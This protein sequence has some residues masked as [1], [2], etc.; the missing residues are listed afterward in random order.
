MAGLCVKSADESRQ[1]WHELGTT[2]W[3]RE[4]GEIP[5]AICMLNVQPDDIIRDVILVKSG[6]HCFNI[7]L[8]L[9]V[10]SALVITKREGTVASVWFLSPDCIAS[11]PALAIAQHQQYVHSPSTD[12]SAHLCHVQVGL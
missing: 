12:T 11:R 5:L 4:S 10:P 7:L 8:I 9:V 2:L 3:S 6:V 1:Q